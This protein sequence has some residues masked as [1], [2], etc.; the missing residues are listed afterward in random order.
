MAINT[1][2][3]SS[4]L[5]FFDGTAERSIYADDGTRGFT[6][7]GSSTIA[8]AYGVAS[9]SIGFGV[10]KRGETWGDITCYTDTGTV[11]LDIG[12]GTNWMNFIAIS[13]T[14]T[15]VT[16]NSNNTFTYLEQR[17]RRFK[18]LSGSP[19]YFSCT[20]SVILTAD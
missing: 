3:A 18:Q 4:S 6:I 20:P 10:S 1:T 5:R 8:T 16:L 11:G 2:A 7:Y 12:D 15:K 13:S 19:T 14:P 9:T 17:I